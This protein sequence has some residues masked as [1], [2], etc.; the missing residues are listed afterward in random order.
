MGGRDSG[1][2]LDFMADCASRIKGRV[3][4]TTDGHRA[5][6]EA[7]EGAFGMDVDYAQLQENLQRSLAMPR[8]GAIRQHS[9]GATLATAAIEGHSSGAVIQEHL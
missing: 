8:R 3:Q 1:W 2:V 5:Y 4:I 9:P 6:L 7:V